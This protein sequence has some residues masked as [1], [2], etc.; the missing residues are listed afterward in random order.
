MKIVY[1]YIVFTFAFLFRINYK[2]LLLLFWKSGVV[3]MVWYFKVIR[4]FH[5]SG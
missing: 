2:T 5:I 4:L 1:C 3:I